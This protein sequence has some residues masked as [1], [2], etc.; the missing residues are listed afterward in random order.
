[1]NMT[2]PTKIQ[3]IDEVYLLRHFLPRVPQ[4]GVYGNDHDAIRA[5]IAVL[6]GDIEL[7]DFYLQGWPD[8]VYHEATLAD[9]WMYGLDDIRPVYNWMRICRN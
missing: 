7:D 1:M 5:Q 2:K 3:I 6:K 9:N 4:W 8:N